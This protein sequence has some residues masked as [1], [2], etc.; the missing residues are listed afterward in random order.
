MP[1]TDAGSIAWLTRGQKSLTPGRNN[2]RKE[3]RKEEER[4]VRSEE[5]LVEGSSELT[6]T[7][8]SSSDAAEPPNIPHADPP[9]HLEEIQL[10]SQR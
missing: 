9:H 6:P 8:G 10:I 1:I 2:G 4:M 5:G 7:K 3:G